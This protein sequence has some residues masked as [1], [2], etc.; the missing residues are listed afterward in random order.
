MKISGIVILAFKSK[1]EDSLAFFGRSQESDVFTECR[2][3]H[4]NTLR[5]RSK[6]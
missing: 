4:P 6:N 2:E 5:E 3:S 1:N